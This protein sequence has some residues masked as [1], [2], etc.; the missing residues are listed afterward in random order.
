MGAQALEVEGGAVAFVLS[1]GVLGIGGVQFLHSIIARDLGEDACGGD[2]EAEGVPTD[3]G[4]L[5]DGEGVDGKS[6][7]EG[8]VGGGGEAEDGAAHALVGGAEDV[9][10]VDFLGVD[11]DDAGE[12]LGEGAE[13]CE[14]FLPGFRG[15]LFGVGEF[16]V[17]EIL[18]EDHRG[19][20]K[21]AG[22]GAPS[23]LID[24]GDAPKASGPE[25][26]LV[27]E[28]AP[29]RRERLRVWRVGRHRVWR[30]GLARQFSAFFSR[31]RPSPACPCGSGG[32]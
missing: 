7:D 29:G 20:K 22:E 27:S 5:G 15:E 14:D 31:A 19:D 18:G 12:D 11:F 24:A 28:G 6:V 13:F 3:E 16:G 2:A 4:G 17:G 30:E 9:E 23:G 26:I 1:E 8:V 21:R 25:R 10:A 32:N